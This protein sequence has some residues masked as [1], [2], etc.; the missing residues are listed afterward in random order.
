MAPER[1]LLAAVQHLHHLNHEVT[2]EKRRTGNKYVQTGMCRLICFHIWKTASDQQKNG[3]KGH[4]GWE[5][6][7]RTNCQINEQ[8][9]Q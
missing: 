7:M 8:E 6:N 9:A 3:G 4:V 2:E 5:S 1:L